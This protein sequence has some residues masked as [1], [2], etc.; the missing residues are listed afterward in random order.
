[1]KPMALSQL[2]LCTN[3]MS[4]SLRLYSEL[5][6]FANAG[7]SA[8]WGDLAR[9]EG[10]TP[11]AH[12]VMWWMVGG[13]PFFQLELFHHGHPKQKP[14]PKDW[15]PSDH[16][17]VRFGVAVDD[18]DRVVAGLE[19]R[20]VPVLGIKGEAGRRRL[21]FRD[22]QA[23]AIV[24]V[25]EAASK[26][27]PTVVY[28]TASVADLART[29]RLYEDLLGAETLPLERLHTPEDEALWGLAG[30]ERDGFL[31]PLGDDAFLEIVH[32]TSPAGRPRPADHS[33]A[34]QGVMNVGLGSRD[35]PAVRALIARCQAEG[36]KITIPVDG[37]AAGTYVVEP[38]FELELMG[39]P[40]ALDKMYGFTKGPRFVAEF[41]L[42]D[43]SEKAGD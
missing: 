33:I 36:V 9:V 23:G 38:D 31:V 1:M 34:D 13:R 8:F 40:E 20:D 27:A 28:A 17:W 22:P 11:D 25:M 5:F 14:Q 3:D 16:G 6:G 37:E 35:V 24:E 21:T 42:A 18:F 29:R 32:Y 30:A 15:R 12:C 39:V 41:D 10:L 4:A 43:V 19:R 2:A 26:A 7:G